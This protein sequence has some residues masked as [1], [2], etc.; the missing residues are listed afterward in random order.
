[1]ERD[2][3]IPDDLP[4]PVRAQQQVT[5]RTLQIDGSEFEFSGGFTDLHKLVYEDTLAGNGFG[6][7]MARP[8]IE[9]QGKSGTI[10]VRAGFQV[11][12]V[13]DSVGSATALAYST[14]TEDNVYY[15]TDFDDI[16]FADAFAK[17]GNLTP[18]EAR[19]RFKDAI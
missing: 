2:G 12:D 18:D 13:P 10:S 6:I 19:E 1:M 11:A 15:G 16:S 3:T 4:E 17:A 14:A 7:D 8:S 5:H 9:L